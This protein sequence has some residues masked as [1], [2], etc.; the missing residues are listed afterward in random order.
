MKILITGSSGFIGSHLVEFLKK[1]YNVVPYDKKEGR[2]ILDKK[3][4]AKKM[5]GC[6]FVVHLAAF[7]SIVDSVKNPTECYE[8]NVIGTSNVVE[9]AIKMASSNDS[10][11]LGGLEGGNTSVDPR[12]V[13]HRTIMEN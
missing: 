8:N 4:L 10:N 1:D 13:F 12:D 2:D 9:E 5:K 7:A 6:E 11:E 3:L